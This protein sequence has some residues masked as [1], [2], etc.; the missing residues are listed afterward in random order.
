MYTLRK[1]LLVLIR[2]ALICF[3]VFSVFLTARL[4][5]VFFG[6]TLEEIPMSKLVL[7]LGRV[8]TIKFLNQPDIQTPYGGFF[9]VNTCF[10][11]LFYL[12]LAPVGERV[13]R[14]IENWSPKR[15]ARD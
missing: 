8:V 10:T 11:L 12:F 13:R 14:A 1:V 3:A 7:G 9:E 2:I 4:V 5:L 15:V 6:T